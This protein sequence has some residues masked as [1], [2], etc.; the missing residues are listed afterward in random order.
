MSWSPLKGLFDFADTALQPAIAAM[1][2]CHT[3]ANW[4]EHKNG[5]VEPVFQDPALLEQLQ[6]ISSAWLFSNHA[7]KQLF[8]TFLSESKPLKL[9]SGVMEPLLKSVIGGLWKKMPLT[10]LVFN[11]LLQTAKKIIYV[12]QLDM[13]SGVGPRTMQAP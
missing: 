4:T 9:V 6:R 12:M 2:I 10:L 13:P 3:I 5:E 7:L 11:T 8:S 1:H